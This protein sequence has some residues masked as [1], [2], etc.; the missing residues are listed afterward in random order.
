MENNKNEQLKD[1]L[2]KKRITINEFSKSLGYSR[3]HISG[4]INGQT[5]ITI[6][7]AKDI[8]RTTNGEVTVENLLGKVE[9]KN[10]G[11]EIEKT[12]EINI[13]CT[14]GS[15]L[16][17]LDLYLSYFRKHTN[18]AQHKGLSF[19]TKG[20]LLCFTHYHDFTPTFE[21]LF[22]L[23]NSKHEKITSEELKIILYESMENG[24][25]VTINGGSFPRFKFLFESFGEK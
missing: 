16:K 23:I 10:I 19:R 24:Y 7:L 4:I 17:I 14:C 1:Y 22:D 18:L 21:E 11:N 12:N 6:R 20:V 9:S 3:N 25:C 8:E 2:Y 13:K 15:E 5:K